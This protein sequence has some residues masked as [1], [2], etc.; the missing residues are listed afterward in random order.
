MACCGLCFKAYL[1]VSS[2]SLESKEISRISRKWQVSVS[3][4]IVSLPVGTAPRET[5][6]TFVD[7]DSGGDRPL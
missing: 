2:E 5:T 1:L 7:E 4:N 3:V 6:G